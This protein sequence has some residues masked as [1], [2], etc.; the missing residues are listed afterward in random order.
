MQIYLNVYRKDFLIIAMVSF[1][2]DVFKSLV[3]VN[4]EENCIIQK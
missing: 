1:E 2:Q 3:R 4:A